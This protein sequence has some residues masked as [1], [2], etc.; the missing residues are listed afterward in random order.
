MNVAKSE[1]DYKAAAEMFLEIKEYKDSFELY[2]ECLHFAE[3]ARKNVILANAKS[4]MN[5]NTAS[6]YQEAIDLLNSISEWKNADSLKLEC[7]ANIEKEAKRKKKVKKIILSLLAASALG[8]AMFFVTVNVI[9]PNIDYNNA[10][11]LMEAQKYEEAI[12]A[13]GALNGYK[14]SK[15]KASECLNEI[16]YNE[17]ISLMNSKAY[18]SATEIFVSLDGYKN[19][20]DL[21]DE[22][23]MQ[24][25]L[26]SLTFT[27][28]DQNNGYVISRFSNDA[29]H[30][31]LI[32]IPS[33]YNG[34][35]VIEIGAYAFS[36]HPNIANV[37]IPN[38]VTSLSAGAFRNCSELESITIP[39]SVTTID[40]AAFK[41]C[42]SLSTVYYTGSEVKWNYINISSNNDNLLNANI[43]FNYVPEQ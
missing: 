28:N 14:D 34:L 30:I 42:T 22:C 40:N 15:E 19:S 23:N 32:E 2:E 1:A 33:Q 4:L 13:F 7:Q 21:I 6:S 26:N 31:Y 36:G 11:E 41:G 9:I 17:A 5:K 39:D 43:I 38:S 27:L 16:K 10:L 18:E 8:I 25:A 24:I 3:G 37:I 20:K 35:P 29:T 12:A